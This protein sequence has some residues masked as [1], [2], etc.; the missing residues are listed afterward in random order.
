MLNFIIGKN[1]IGKSTILKEVARRYT[2]PLFN[3]LSKQVLNYSKI[4]IDNDI[5]KEV[6]TRLNHGDPITDEYSVFAIEKEYWSKEY[7]STLELLC[8]KC[9]S[10]F[11]DEIDDTL[12]SI[13]CGR[14]FN[15][16]NTVSYFKDVWC[17][18]H[19]KDA[20]SYEGFENVKFYTVIKDN[21]RLNL[22]EVQ[23]NEIEEYSYSI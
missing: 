6:I 7:I 22:K 19:S 5:L 2:N 9:D 17:I 1:S 11:L 10:L 14:I 4:K 13:E 18:T 12:E 8:K 20:M 16:I 21:C 23:Y 3:N 15:A